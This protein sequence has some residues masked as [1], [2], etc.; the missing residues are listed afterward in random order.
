MW[1][2][3][4][5]SLPPQLFDEAVKDYDLSTGTSTALNSDIVKQVYS[6]ITPGLLDEFDGPQTFPLIAPIPLLILNG[7]LDPRNPIGG[8]CGVVSTTKKVYAQLDCTPETFTALAQRDTAHV[9]TDAML[10]LTN[11]WL[12]AT[13]RPEGCAVKSRKEVVTSA[14]RDKKTWR[15][16]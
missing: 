4:V 9:C 3:R 16:L 10:R 12:D 15:E 2:A 13:L 14:L 5:A 11:Q 8:V 6:R 1:R 7:E